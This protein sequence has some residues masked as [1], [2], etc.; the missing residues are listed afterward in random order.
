VKYKISDFG[1]AITHERKAEFDPYMQA[2]PNRS[3]SLC[4][5]SLCMWGEQYYKIIDGLL[6]IVGSDWIGLE[7][8]GAYMC[9]PLSMDGAYN[10]SKLRDV[11]LAVKTEVCPNGEPM[12]ILG[13]TE[14]QLP[15]YEEALSDIAQP[16]EDQESWDYIYQRSDLEH[17]IGR[18]YAVKR[19]HINQLKAEWKYH[20]ETI[21]PACIGELEEALDVFLERKLEQEDPGSLIEIEVEAVRKILP[22][23]EKLGMFG[24]YI[25]LEGKI[26]AFT[27]GSMIN[28]QMVDVAVEKA[29]PTI[30]GLYQAINREFAKSLPPEVLYINREEDMGV[31]GLRQAKRSYHPCCMLKVYT[32]RF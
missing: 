5:A 14:G 30:R 3:S 8:P 23:Y 6:C 24:G 2:N 10:A 31:K 4:F 32:Y 7:F 19:N 20:Y 17:L 27:M 1:K 11:I 9:T 26:K 16:R 25:R 15:L 13:V 29:D 12:M 22:I 28:P 21:T 18:K